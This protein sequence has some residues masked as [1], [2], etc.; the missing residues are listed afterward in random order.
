M[1]WQDVEVGIGE[2]AGCAGGIE[3]LR[4]IAALKPV[5]V[6]RVAGNR[7]LDLKRRGL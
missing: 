4:P 6:I 5:S 1:E 7:V 2:F 3:A